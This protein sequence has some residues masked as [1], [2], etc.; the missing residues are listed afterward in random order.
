MWRPLSL[1]TNLGY[2]NFLLVLI[3]YSNL[4]YKVIVGD[5]EERNVSIKSEN[6]I[7]GWNSQGADE[8]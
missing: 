3:S 8:I 5:F 2:H 1:T 7:S 6:S 4:K